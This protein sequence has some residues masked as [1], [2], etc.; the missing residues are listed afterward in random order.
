MVD[1][2]LMSNHGSLD[3]SDLFRQQAHRSSSVLVTFPSFTGV[4]LSSVSPPCS[5][6]D[7]LQIGTVACSAVLLRFLLCVPNTL[8]P[9]R[10]LHPV[11]P[12]HGPSVSSSQVHEDLLFPVC[13][14]HLAGSTEKGHLMFCGSRHP[15]HLPGAEPCKAVE[16]S[17][18]L[19]ML[20]LASDPLRN[21]AE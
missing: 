21:G 20:P 8:L 16:L 9:R 3:S 1:V 4:R 10:R 12:S 14:F 19:P 2:C 6:R 11:L 13:T 18:T 17:Q 7:P 5:T 15:P